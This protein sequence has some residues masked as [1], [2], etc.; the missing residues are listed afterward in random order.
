[1]SGHH[2]NQDQYNST[3]E[4]QSCHAVGIK[5]GF[6]DFV[7]A[8]GIDNVKDHGKQDHTH[9]KDDGNHENGSPASD[10]GKGRHSFLGMQ[11]QG[12]AHRIL[13]SEEASVQKT[14]DG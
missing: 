12:M 9:T 13:N 10:H 6:A 11:P 2:Q 14:E 3:V 5:D 4:Y 1:M 8:H 7:R